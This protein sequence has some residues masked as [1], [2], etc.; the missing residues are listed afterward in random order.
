MSSSFAN[1]LQRLRDDPESALPPVFDRYAERLIR[2]ARSRIAARL[3]AGVSA[4]DVVQEALFSFFRRQRERP[5]ELHNEEALWGLLAKI[6]LFKC[7]KMVQALTAQKRGG[8][9]VLPLE[10][11]ADSDANWDVADQEPTPEEAL[12]LEETVAEL[13]RRLGDTEQQVCRLCLEGYTGREIAERLDLTEETVSRKLR[14]VKDCL[15]QLADR[16]G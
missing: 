7:G 2:L 5:F 6:T 14:K 8:G 10:P 16:E 15:L 13:L 12:I 9:K 11:T 4:S 3:R 1:L